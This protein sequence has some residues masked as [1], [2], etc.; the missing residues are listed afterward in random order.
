MP[1]L[2]HESLRRGGWFIVDYALDNFSQLLG[3]PQAE[4]FFPQTG[5]LIA[6]D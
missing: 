6:Y 4:S 1:V 5:P 3:P 2:L